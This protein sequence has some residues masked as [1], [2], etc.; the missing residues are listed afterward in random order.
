MP[1]VTMIHGIGN[2]RAADQLLASW[3][4]ALRDQ[5]GINLET[6]GVSTSMVYWA[7]VLYESPSVGESH[8]STGEEV[9]TTELDEDFTWIEELPEEDQAFIAQLQAEWAPNLEPPSG[10]GDDYAAPTAEADGTF[11]RIPIPWAIKRRMMKVLLRDVHHYLFNSVSRP[12]PD[13]EYQVQDEIRN[14]FVAAIEA[15]NAQN[16]GGPHVVLSHS[17]GT[18]IAYDCLKRDDRCEGVDALM[19]IGSPLGIDE[20]Q[21][22]MKP[23]WT[24]DD[25][26]PSSK[27]AS[28]WANVYD[29]LDVV[30]RLDPRIS[31]D[32][33]RG[34]ADVIDDIEVENSGLWRHDISAYLRRTELREKLV[35][36]LQL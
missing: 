1:H 4:F 25:G 36:Q 35:S 27:V 14:R 11:E 33:R 28:D 20:I 24:R 13:E 18:V 23:Q 9:L 5:G 3:E 6:S 31:N 32:Y 12:R 26:F 30:S 7:D 10:Q 29:S 8:E 34:G 22:K 17:M 21:D 15:G 2:K 19:T 16:T